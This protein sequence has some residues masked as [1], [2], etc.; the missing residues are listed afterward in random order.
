MPF[1]PE[2][3]TKREIEKEKERQREG[4]KERWNSGTIRE[5]ARQMKAMCLVTV[6]CQRRYLNLGRIKIL[7]EGSMGVKNTRYKLN[8]NLVCIVMEFFGKFLILSLC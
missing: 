2:R 5:R 6:G 3:E 7:F 4:E 8:V 1:E